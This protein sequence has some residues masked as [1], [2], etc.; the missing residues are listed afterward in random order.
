MYQ[1]P[2]TGTHSSMY[3]IPVIHTDESQNIERG[4]SWVANT[5]EGSGESEVPALVP[6]GR[7]CG[8]QQ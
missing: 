7:E 5:M 3:T 1:V 4:D 2:G 8:Q 6:D